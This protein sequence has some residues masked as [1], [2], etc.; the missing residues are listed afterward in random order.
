MDYINAIIFGIAQGLTE[1]LPVSSSGHLIILR[2]FLNI[3]IQNELSFDVIL[4]F[5][6]LLAVSWYF[7]KDILD[8]ARASEPAKAKL[9]WLIILATIP[10]ALAGFFLEEAIEYIF[11]DISVVIAM[12]AIIGVLFIVAEKISKKEKEI[13]SLNWTKALTVGLAQA[14]ALVPGTSR[15][16][17]T[18]IAGMFLGLKREEA[19]RFSFLLSIPIIAGASLAKAPQIMTT[20]LSSI[21]LN[22]LAISFLA[23]LFSGFFT[24]KYFLKFAQNHSL[25]AFAYYRF[26]LAVLLGIF[27]IA[28]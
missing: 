14:L 16:G 24:I 9:R 15:S 3:P 10:A 22:I 12:L 28:N 11:R 5:A 25:V 4:H 1:F 6:T 2:Q 27:L 19:I 26:A 23:S 8:L 20:S 17:I 21:E 13:E 7:R 18:I